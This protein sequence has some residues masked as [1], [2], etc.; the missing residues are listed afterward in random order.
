VS[1]VFTCVYVSD[2]R[3]RVSTSDLWLEDTPASGAYLLVS[4]SEGVLARRHRVC[5]V[6]YQLLMA[7]GGL[8]PEVTVPSTFCPQ[9]RGPQHHPESHGCIDPTMYERK[10]VQ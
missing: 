10:R 2:E 6:L 4:G 7:N 3:K 1:P 8:S 5:S 9:G